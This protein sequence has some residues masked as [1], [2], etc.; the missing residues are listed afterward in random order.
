P[1]QQKVIVPGAFSAE[2]G[3]SAIACSYKASV[4]LLYPLERGFTFVPRPPVSIRFDE[5]ITAQFS[6][7]TGAQSSYDFEVEA[8]NGLTHTFTSID[9]NE[10]HQLFDFVTSKELRV[11]NIDS[12]TKPGA[13][14]GAEDGWFSSDESHYAY[15]EKVKTQARGRQIGIEED[16]DDDED[17][18]EHQPPPESKAS[19]LA[20]ECDNPNMAVEDIIKRIKFC[21]NVLVPTNLKH[22]GSYVQGGIYN[23]KETDRTNL[24]K[25]K[26]ESSPDFS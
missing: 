17:D 16:D 14:F 24:L 22:I 9:R 19:E 3:G 10:Y 12:E 18:G 20:E 8:R 25:S 6:R 21:I 26:Q 13:A 7:G 1:F 15:M 5:V 23:V 11:K 4:G 2:G